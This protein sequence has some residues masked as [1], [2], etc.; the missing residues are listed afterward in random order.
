M[1]EIVEVAPRDGLQNDKVILPTRTKLELIER[2]IAAG[3]RRMEATSFVNPTKVP[4]MADADELSRQLPD[5]DG[6]VYQGLVL[7]RRG[8][9]RAIAAGVDE[10]NVVVVAT[11]TFATKNQGST[12]D[13]TVQTALDVVKASPVPV[14]ATIA[15]AFGCP[16]EGEVP[17]RRVVEIAERL[18]G[19]GVAELALAD[20]IGVGGPAEV[21]ERF[22]AVREVAGGLKLRAHFHNTRNTGLANAWAAVEAGVHILDASLGGT[23]GCPFAPGATG[24][25]ATEDLVYM[26]ERGGLQTGL[27][28]DKLLEATAW[29]EGVLGRK[30]PGM[31]GKAG[32]FPRAMAA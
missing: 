17:V 9:E 29:F 19:S 20:T 12:S 7:N 4:A 6:V 31:L 23:G 5:V 15:V 30:L 26:L 11:D 18:A 22:R 1:I 32:R 8:L 13:Q 16:F 24:N 3:V 2:L 28:L 14:S 25:I 10:V 21:T 27:D